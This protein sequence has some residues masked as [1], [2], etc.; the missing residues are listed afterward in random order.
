MYDDN[1]DVGD[2]DDNEDYYTSDKY[3]GENDDSDNDVRKHDSGKDKNIHS[4]NTDI[5]KNG[6]N[7][8]SNGSAD[9]SDIEMK[10][11]ID[12]TTTKTENI[13]LNKD[14]DQSIKNT[15]VASNIKKQAVVKSA[16]ER[17]KKMTAGLCD[18]LSDYGLVSFLPLNIQDGEVTDWLNK[19]F[20]FIRWTIIELIVCVRG[21][22]VWV[23][24]WIII[25][26]FCFYFII[27]ISHPTSYFF[28]TLPYSFF[29]NLL[30]RG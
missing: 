11:K 21:R 29:L 25:L 3:C 4:S 12:D 30:D 1:H 13:T 16:Q 26:Q 7:N 9:V 24:H 14:V 20:D 17:R 5:S 8:D 6:D 10:N 23:R 15:E 19:I 2:D 27:F 28:E 18:V 22:Q